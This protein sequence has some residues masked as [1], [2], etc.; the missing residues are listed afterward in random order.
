MDEPAAAAYGFRSSADYFDWLRDDNDDPDRWDTLRDVRPASVDFW[1]RS[2]PAALV[3][4]AEGPTPARVRENPTDNTPGMLRLR[5][6][7]D[8]NLFAFHAVPPRVSAASGQRRRQR[9]RAVRLVASV[10]RCRPRHGGIH[11][12]GTALHAGTVRRHSRCLGG[13]VADGAQR[14]P[15]HRGGCLARPSGFVGRLLAMDTVGA[16]PA[17]DRAFGVGVDLDHR[18]Q[19]WTVRHLGR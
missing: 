17:A 6:D 19:L 2:S 5:L 3:P 11:A 7:L 12:C 15:A 1:W 8:G 14:T 16:R 4:R 10:R 9:I 13:C 18:H